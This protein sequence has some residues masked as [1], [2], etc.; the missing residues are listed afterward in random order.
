MGTPSSPNPPNAVD[1][2]FAE[3]QAQL[4]KLQQSMAQG[5]IDPAPTHTQIV[6]A[7]DTAPGH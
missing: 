1:R 5:G 7:L 6:A 4:T 3:L 2:L